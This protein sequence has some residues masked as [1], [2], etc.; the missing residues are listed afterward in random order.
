MKKNLKWVFI[1]QKSS[2]FK[3]NLLIMKLSLLL[4]TVITLQVSASVY[5]QQI[6]I[7][8]NTKG[9]TVRNVLNIIEK[10]GKVRFFY[11]D[12]FNQLDKIISQNIENG[13]LSQILTAVCEEAQLSYKVMENNFIV[14]YPQELQQ[15]TTITG[16]ITDAATGEPLPGVNILVQGTT[17]G[18]ITDNNGKYTLPNV[19]ESSVLIFSFIGYIQETITVGDQTVID[20]AL[21]EDITSLQ[22]VVV[23]GYGTVRKSDLTGSVASVKADDIK[24][25]GSSNIQ[26]ALQ[27]K[28]S[29]VSIESGSGQPGSGVRILIRGTSTLN[30]NNPLYIVDGIPVENINNINSSDVE[31]MEVLKDA[32]ASAIY[33]SRASNGV[34]LVTTKSGVDGET[35]FEVN[36]NYGFQK[37]TKSLDVLNATQFA[38]VEKD[39]YVN[40]GLPVPERFQNPAQYGV[41]TDWQ[42]ELYRVAPTSSFDVSASGGNNNLNFSVSGGNINQEGIIQNTYYNRLNFR[43]KTEFKKGRFTFGESAILSQENWRNAGSLGGRGGG[44]SGSAVKMVPIFPVYDPAEIGGYSGPSTDYL[45][46]GNPVAM[47]KLM[48]SKRKNLNMLINLYGQFNIFKDLNYK[49]NVGYTNIGG[50]NYSYTNRYTMGQFINLD[51]DLSETRFQSNL[52]L[53]EHTLNYLKD[54]GNH[55]IQAFVGYSFQTN[56]YRNLNGSKSNMADGI[57]VLDAGNTNIATGGSTTKSTLESYLGRVIYSYAD[58]YLLTATFRR[59]GSSRFSKNNRNGIFP[60][61]ALG[62]NV[63]NESFFTPLAKTINLMKLRASY[64]V[65][66]NQEIGNYLYNAAIQQSSYALAN[67]ALWVGGTVRDFA[68]TEVKWEKSK[69]LNVGVDLGFLANKLTFTS[70]YFIQRNSDILLNVP[71]PLSAGSSSDPM[72]NAG[73][74]LNRGIENT[75]SYKSNIGELKYRINATFTSVKNKVEKLGMEGQQIFGGV[76]AY[77]KAGSTLTQTGGEVGAFYLIKTDGIF[78]S[79]EDVNMYTKD[80]KKIQPQAQPGDVRFVDYNNDGVISEE[81]RQYC[82]SPTP[83]FEYGFGVNMNYKGF[84][85]YIFLQGTYG[86]KI[87]NGVRQDLENPLLA[88]NHSTELLNAWT[89]QNHSDIPRLTKGLDPNNNTRTSDRFLEDGSYLR[90]KTIQLGYT[91]PVALTN[92]INISSVRIFASADNLLTFTKYTGYNPDLG[93]MGS[94][95]DRGV[96]L[97]SISY[98]L[99]TTV[100]FGFQVSF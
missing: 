56:D 15:Q 40:S 29:G 62:W 77:D 54:F 39:G 95:L 47:V 27:G 55:H 76:P 67:N 21:I 6:I 36:A 79:I 19:S 46:I 65:L 9:K 88:Q 71:L 66:G 25:E 94:I 14:V 93:R 83:K 87:F 90:L 53:Q 13:E 42:K 23:V 89:D 12:D 41:G 85:L 82:G 10:E 75:I 69:T 45:D 91:L 70:D 18:T 73:E 1:A 68:S 98:P 52:L 20:V 64:G 35:K 30:N 92:K 22:E 50:Y 16:K 2:S 49:Y 97:G 44:P 33:G 99:S 57:Y 38:Q 51:N 43:V 32:S 4:T 81:D 72:V 78:N 84:D 58:K 24:A 17:Q 59:D 7:D 31:S 61:L 96:D 48:D 63:S 100:L 5:S 60:S 34:V 3:N 80:D 86:N 28:T 26:M 37:L 74:I 8:Q 11:N